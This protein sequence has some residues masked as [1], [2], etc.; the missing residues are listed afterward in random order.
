MHAP[1]RV[2]SNQAVVLGAGNFTKVRSLSSTM[3]VL[4]LALTL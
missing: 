1:L 4:I 2:Q 3:E